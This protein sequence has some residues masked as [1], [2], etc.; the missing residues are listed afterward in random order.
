MRRRALLTPLLFLAWL[1]TASQEAL[2]FSVSYD[3]VIADGTQAISS[4]VVMKDQQFRIETTVIGT[5]TVILRNPS[6]IYN[7]LPAQ[8]VAMRLPSMEATQ[9]LVPGIDDYRRHLQERNAKLLRTETVN[10]YLCDVYEYTDPSAAGMTTAWVWKE[11]QFPVKLELHSAHSTT[12]VDITNV[13]FD[14]PIS[15]VIFQLP[16]GV[17][18]M[19][20]DQL[21]AGKLLEGP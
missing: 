12:M 6:G 9:Q 11:R 2:A 20:A 10:G 8:G 16:V 15:E 4:T 7:Y 18:I 1:G 13:R 3:Q 17:Q 21:G 5:P 14:P 19:D